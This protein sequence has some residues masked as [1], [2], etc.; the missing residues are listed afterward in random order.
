MFVTYRPDR[1]AFATV[2]RAAQFWD[3][4]LRSGPFLRHS[5]LSLNA[6]FVPH[7]LKHVIGLTVKETHSKR[8]HTAFSEQTERPAEKLR[9][10]RGGSKR[11]G[12]E[13]S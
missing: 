8:L 12:R 7:G 6:T 13:E 10:E 9:L 5:L 11:A 4:H 3:A 1:S 2:G